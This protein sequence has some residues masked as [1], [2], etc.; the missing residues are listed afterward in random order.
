MAKGKRF[1]D[2]LLSGKEDKWVNI[3]PKAAVIPHT[4]NAVGWQPAS[5]E[6][7]SQYASFLDQADSEI[8]AFL[9]ATDA[10]QYNPNFYEKIIQSQLELA[11]KQLVPQIHDHARAIHAIH[12]Y[13]NTTL[14]QL[15]Q[16]EQE[17]EKAIT[18]F[19]TE[20]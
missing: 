15:M 17:L 6:I 3:T 16:E 2:K 20:E 11:Q 12:V 19:Q 13:Q 1:F 10:D 8:K 7:P 14:F 5:Y 4:T 9:Q 18:H